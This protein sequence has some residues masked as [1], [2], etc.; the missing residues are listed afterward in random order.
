MTKTMKTFKTTQKSGFTLIELL[1]VIGLLAALA[2]VLLPALMGDRTA[3]LTNICDY[4]QAGTLRTLRQYEAFTSGKL[5]NGLH[6]GLVSSTGTDF[7]DLPAA[8]KKNL[9]G[10]VE[11]LTGN[12]VAALN[13][14]GIT[15]LAYGS[16]DP[17]GHEIEE[18]LGYKTLE[19]GDNVIICTEDW[20]DDANNPYSFNGKGL[21]YLLDHDSYTKVIPVF[22]TPTTDWTSSQSGNW[23]KGFN[24]SMDIAGSCP[25]PDDVEFAYYVA[26]IGIRGEGT[27]S[28]RSK[29]ATA[30][31]H[32][33]VSAPAPASK[34]AATE[35]LLQ[36]AIT[37]AVNGATDWAAGTW[38]DDG[39][40]TATYDNGTVTGTVTYTTTLDPPQ[41][42][43]LGTSC[44]ECGITNP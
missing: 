8:F 19:A 5:P 20:V 29:I 40:M 43:L 42:H 13:S 32:N 37:T 28:Y 12:E 22:I 7:M 3:A 25:V 18:S 21:H 24:V 23:V 44:P 35:A 9:T 10:S 14:I 36:T 34:T 30:L 38:S 27:A 31:D 1:I 15:E 4:N 16:G 6:S 2:S 11:A 26:Y 33:G 39:V 17:D 41:A